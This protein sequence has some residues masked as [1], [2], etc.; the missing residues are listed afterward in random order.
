ML[1]RIDPLTYKY[2]IVEPNGHYLTDVSEATSYENEVVWDMIV[3]AT[4][5]PNTGYVLF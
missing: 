3:I 2:V 4:Y 1:L 5:T